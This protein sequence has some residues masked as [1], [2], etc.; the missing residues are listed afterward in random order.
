MFDNNEICGKPV[1]E[2]T[3][4]I[5]N[6]QRSKR[7]AYPWL[8]AIYFE[9]LFTCGGNLVSDRHIVTAAHCITEK[10][11]YD[12]KKYEV[13]MGLYALEDSFGPEAVSRVPQKLHVHPHYQTYSEDKADGDIAIIVFKAITFTTYVSIRKTT[14]NQNY[15]MQVRWKKP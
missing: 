12:P 6:G 5:V 15:F 1:R 2:S 11:S 7:G 13:V 9:D 3:P 10:E 14:N 8:T 4:L